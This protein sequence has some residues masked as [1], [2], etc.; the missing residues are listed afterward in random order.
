MGDNET[1]ERCDE[2]AVYSESPEHVLKLEARMSK[3]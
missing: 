3:S 2:C 1:M